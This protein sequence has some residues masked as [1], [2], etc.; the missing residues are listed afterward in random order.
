MLLQCFCSR[1]LLLVWC[2]MKRDHDGPC[3]VDVTDAF[4][5]P[6]AE[7][8]MVYS[9]QQLRSLTPSSLAAVA[10]EDLNA[11]VVYSY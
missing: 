10:A 6:G 9:Q 3:R 8:P 7:V 2:D 5:E 11:R 1:V 4:Q